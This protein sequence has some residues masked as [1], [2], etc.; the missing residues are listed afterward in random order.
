[1]LFYHNA[2]DMLLLTD[3]PNLKT[4]ILYEIKSY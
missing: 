4:F 2:I 1:M 3:K